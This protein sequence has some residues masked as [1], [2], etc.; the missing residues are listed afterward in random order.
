MRY[1]V[2][3][4]A[5]TLIWSACSRK[6]QNEV[7]LTQY[8]PE[9]ASVILHVRNLSNFKSEML[10]CD[11]L[12]Q[13]N[14]DVVLPYLTG[15]A[16]L[17]NQVDADSTALLSLTHNAGKETLLLTTYTTSTRFPE[18]STAIVRSDTVISQGISLTTYKKDTLVLYAKT[19]GPVSLW[20][21]N[22]D[23]LLNVTGNTEKGIPTALSRL[24]ETSSAR[25][26]ATL[27]RKTYGDRFMQFF[28]ITNKGSRPDSLPATWQSMDLDLG[29]ASVSGSGIVHQTDSSLTWA[30][31]FRNTSPLESNLAAL[32]PLQ[33]DALLSFS[34]DDYTEYVSNQE[35]YLKQEL[36]LEPIFSAVETGGIIYLNKEKIVVLGMFDAEAL[37]AFL[38]QQQTGSKQFQGSEIISLRDTDFL[39][40]HFNPL[41]S[42]FEARFLARLENQFVF[43][44][45]SKS[46]EKLLQAYNSGSVYTLSPVYESTAKFRSREASLE[47]IANAKGM[48][49]LIEEPIFRDSESAQAVSFQKGFAYT[50]QLVAGTN[51]ALNNMAITRVNKK[52]VRNTT[53]EVFRLQL[54]GEIAT[55]PQ[56][57]IN[58]RN[59]KKEIVVQD[60]EN[61]LYLISG[62]GKI[63]W[64]KQLDSQIQG[65]IQQVDLYKNG[66]LQLAFTT[67]DQFL[68]LDRNGKEVA[69]FSMRFKGGNLNPLAV[70]DYE[71]NRNYRFLVTQGR[72][73]FMYN[74]KGQ[75]VSGFTYTEAESPVLRAPRHFRVGSRDYLVFQLENGSLEIRNRVG[76]T[77]IATDNQF[78]F[79][80]NP[81]YLYR[82]QFTFT[83]KAGVLFTINTKGKLSSSRL[84]LDPV[85]RID[86]TSK[87][88]ATLTENILTIKGK[89]ITLELGVYTAPKIFYLYDKIYVSVTDL[90]G[91]KVYLFDSQTMGIPG[92]PVYGTAGISLDDLDSNRKLELVTKGQG[93]DLILYRMN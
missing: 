24:L 25:K 20:S 60:E 2:S 14:T 44:E 82:N 34:F 84:N 80:D 4:L 55:K 67:N 69:P 49:A 29:Q 45:N 66:R 89:P 41:I 10:N 72:K 42:G 56:F 23:L 59:R 11:Y 90:Q 76:R 50:G 86:A 13:V 38:D 40:T 57:V 62:E 71:N 47:F 36:N 92:F 27:Y 70:F 43:A 33:A 35:A 83:D 52:A 51:F 6:S 48:D 79:S 32:A 19:E 58:H 26:S 7:A 21:D 64:K 28:P 18:D 31:L 77:R 39:N 22:A 5:L 81:V 68:I 17:I 61:K 53:S 63:L 85:H 74:S 88:L 37:E 65:D 12:D 46:L 93:N 9:N 87:T 8:I 15:E 30:S 3:L 75:I 16:G 54:D 91:E 73:I 78:D 1:R